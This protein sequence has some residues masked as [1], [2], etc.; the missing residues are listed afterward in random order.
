MDGRIYLNRVSYIR[1]NPKA[2]TRCVRK[3]LKILEVLCRRGRSYALLFLW[4]NLAKKKRGQKVYGLPLALVVF[5][6]GEEV[7][8]A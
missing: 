8:I 2:N 7:K 1:A 5:S 3:F 4:K 6:T